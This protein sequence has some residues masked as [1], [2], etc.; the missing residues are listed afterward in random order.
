[1]ARLSNSP[2]DVPRPGWRPWIA[3]LLALAVFA[4][5]FIAL[6]RE[7]QQIH[8]HDFLAYLRGISREAVLVAFV[9]TLAS[10]FLLGLFDVAGL[11]YLGRR[12]RYWRV[13]LSSFI[14]YAMSNNLGAAP[15]TGGTVRFRLYTT[16]RLAG[17]EIATLQG[18]CS[19]TNGLGITTLIGASLLAA[20]DQGALALHL[21]PPGSSLVGLALLTTTAA[22]VAW[23]GWGR[24]N[25]RLLGWELRP[26]GLRLVL[27]QV[28]L[29]VLE[30]SIAAAV[31]WALLPSGM[32]VGLVGFLGIYALAVAAGVVSHVPGGLGVFESMML[33]ALSGAPRS[34]LLGALVAYRLIYYLLPLL[35]AGLAFAA[36]ELRE[37]RNRLA[38]VHS[39]LSLYVAPIAP[40]I[41]GTL[42]FLAGVLLLVSGALPALDARVATLRRFV[43]LPILEASHL[44]GSL[45]GVGLLVLARALFHR[46]REAYRLAMLGLIAGMMASL[47][48]G[49]DYEESAILALILAV[50][51]LGRR[52]FHR[53]AS[54]IQDRFTPGWIVTIAGVLATIAWLGFFA[55]RHVE[56]TQDLWWTFASTADAPRMLRATLVTAVAAATWLTLNLLQPAQPEPRLPSAADLAIAQPIADISDAALSNAVLAGDKR[57]L[58]NATK[59]AFIMYQIARRSWIALGDPVGRRDSFEELAWQF[60][61]HADRHDGRVVFYGARPEYL[62]LYIGLGL[63]AVK[64]GE[65][66]R[67]PLRDFSLEGGG[68]APL[69]QA[70]RRAVRDGATFEVLPPDRTATLL[71]SLRRISDAWL[72]E[73]ATSEKGFSVGAFHEAYIR[74]FPLAIVRCDG[75]PVAF[76]N[77][78]P[79]KSRAE[80]SIDLMRFGPDAP[81]SSMDFMFAELMSWGRAQGYGWF[82]LGMAPLAGLERHALAPSWH[83]VGNFVF[84]HGE[85]FYNFEGL[86]RYK[87]KF[88]PVW[89]PRYLVSPPGFFVLPRVLMDASVLIAGGVRGLLTK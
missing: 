53:R 4:A 35:M 17:I 45:S 9:C 8:L 39:M 73:K 68:R 51:W 80:L 56:Y 86:R 19:L 21:R 64:L 23:G 83:R 87:A 40:Y 60:R 81:R 41:V 13:A 49:L 7:V 26:P 11:L 84:R 85:H 63:G 43:P 79:T 37:Q 32:G 33:L 36:L 16:E 62:P 5:A 82:N 76:A 71:P 10:Y 75:E 48:K 74:Q 22:Y 54:L 44:I 77:L 24:G 70:H 42:V 55:Y 72:Q 88:D 2:N 18:F 31:L 27:A 61:E 47:L 59:D 52:A 65:E 6:H 38:H 50:L 66:G 69:R 28:V 58:F 15:I 89:E 20:S 46:V 78:W 1:M 29:G 67:V 3:P 30:L 34:E 57:L 25:L 14:A 12:L